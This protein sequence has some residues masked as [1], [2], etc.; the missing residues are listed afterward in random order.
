MSLL[1]LTSHDAG[2]RHVREK[3]R[4]EHLLRAAQ[5]AAGHLYMKVWYGSS[6]LLKGLGR[7]IRPACSTALHHLWPCREPM[8]SLL[9]GIASV[10]VNRVLGA[11][12]SG[13]K[14]IEPPSTSGGTTRTRLVLFEF[15]TDFDAVWRVQDRAARAG[16]MAGSERGDMWRVRSEWPRG[17]REL[18]QTS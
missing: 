2:A 13:W 5:D 12:M 6:N 11:N 17:E 18:W 15:S 7:A 9:V 14:H 10:L 1:L 3:G 8:S 4:T 16:P